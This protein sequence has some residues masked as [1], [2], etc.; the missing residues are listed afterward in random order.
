MHTGSAT[1]NNLIDNRT[2]TFKSPVSRREFLKNA[3]KVV[4]LVSN[5]SLLASCKAATTSAVSPNKESTSSTLPALQALTVNNADNIRLLKTLEI[6]GFSQ[7]GLSQGSVAFSPDG[8]LLSG[9]CYQNKLPVWDV[10]GGRLLFLLDSSKSPLVAVAFRWDGKMLAAGGFSDSIQ[11]YDPATGKRVGTVGPL[12]F[13]AWELSFPSLKG[14]QGNVDRLASANF[15][16]GYSYHSDAGSGMTLWNTTSGG[17]LWDYKGDGATSRVLSVDYAADGKTIAYGT[18]DS[19]LVVEAET[20]SLLHALPIPNH[21]GDLAF[22]PDGQ[23]LAAGS[24]DNVIRLWQAGQFQ[25]QFELKGHS[26]YVNGVTFSPGGSL[27]VSGSHDQRIG[28]WDVKSG[29]L[30]AWLQGHKS[31][32]LRVAVNPA[33][34]LIASISWDGTVRLWGVAA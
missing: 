28:V 31:A 11:L 18:F 1:L 14:S 22:S 8:K 23:W 3:A 7:G 5:L 24:D 27:L 2:P 21:V 25:L 19:A 20:G 15:A 34:T 13:P 17:L 32:V 33:G 29:Q 10:P 30:L 16:N 12:P 6:P 4:A 26:N 9:A